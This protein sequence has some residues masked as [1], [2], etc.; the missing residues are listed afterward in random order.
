MTAAPKVTIAGG[1]I[2]GMTTALRLAERGYRVKLYEQKSMLGGNLATRTLVN[3]G[4]LDV[5][6]HMYVSW[7]RNFWRLLED[8]GVDRSKRFTRFRKVKTRHRKS[9]KWRKRCDSSP[10]AKGRR[11]KL[12][13]I[14]NPRKTKHLGGTAR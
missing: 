11:P 3:G 13:D 12:R 14:R 10:I 7:Y 6:P 1:G 5:Y 4:L 8:V 2:A 9:Y